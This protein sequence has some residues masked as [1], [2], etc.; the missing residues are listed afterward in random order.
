VIETHLERFSLL[1]IFEIPI[2]EG[3]LPRSDKESPETKGNREF[4][5]SRLGHLFKKTMLMKGKR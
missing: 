5:I 3:I 2:S 1:L 4:L